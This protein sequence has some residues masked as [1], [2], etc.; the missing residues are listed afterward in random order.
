M[1]TKTPAKYY[2]IGKNGQVIHSGQYIFTGTPC[3]KVCKEINRGW[4]IA[5][6]RKLYTNNFETKQ[7]KVYTY[8]IVA[9]N[10][11]EWTFRM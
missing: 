8:Q 5:Y 6:L 4:R 11:R 7:L 3:R 10:G 2:A 9:D 1:R